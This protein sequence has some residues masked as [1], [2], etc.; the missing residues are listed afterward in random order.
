MHQ[1]AAI[2]RTL[3]LDRRLEFRV[4]NMVQ[5]RGKMK[6]STPVSVNGPP[7]VSDLTSFPVFTSNI[8]RVCSSV[9]VQLLCV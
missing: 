3:P 4:P 9:C 5:T 1:G 2:P 6:L 7:K 8:F